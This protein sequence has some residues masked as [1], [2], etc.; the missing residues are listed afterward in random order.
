M[1]R[2]LTAADIPQ[3]TAVACA[4]FTSDCAWVHILPEEEARRRIMPLLFALTYRLDL[5]YGGRGLVIEEDG[6]L[7]A[8]ALCFPAGQDSPPLSAWLRQAHRL[9]PLLARPAAA[10][11]ALTLLQSVE[12]LRP[13]RLAYLKLLTVAPE[14]QGKGLGSALIERLRAEAGAPLYLETF[15]PRNVDYYQQRGFTL[16]LE[17]Q[18]PYRPIFWTFS[19]PGR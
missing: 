5:D 2:P 1:I 12:R 4:A 7:L 17:V 8:C 19:S 18:S 14:A 11:R 16:R 9:L 6:K 15:N 10:L 3:A 13:K